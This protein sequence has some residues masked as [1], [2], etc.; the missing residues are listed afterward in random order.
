[1][2]KA[3]PRLLALI[4]CWPLLGW[5]DTDIN[6]QLPWD[7]EFRFAGY[8]A[9][10]DKGLYAKHDMRVNILSGFGPQ[11]TPI[12]PIEQ[13]LNGKAQFG[14]AGIE[15]LYHP[16]AND[17]LRILAPIFQQ[18]ATSLFSLAGTPLSKLQDLTGKRI[19]YIGGSSQYYE[20]QSLLRQLG[21]DTDSIV[22]TERNIDLNDL[23]EGRAD[24]IL[25]YGPQIQ[26]QAQ[27]RQ[28]AVNELA[29]NNFHRRYYGD[30][31]FTSAEFAERKPKHVADFMTASQ[32]GWHYALDHTDELV[33]TLLRKYPRTYLR[34][35]NLAAY[36]QFL[37][38][39]LGVY[40]QYPAVPVGYSDPV[41]WQVVVDALLQVGAIHT[42]LN[43]NNL[44]WKPEENT[45]DYKQ[46]L[47]YIAA[48]CLCI[49]LILYF[50]TRGRH[51]PLLVVLA[52][53]VILGTMLVERWL[54]NQKHELVKI[55]Q[56][57]NNM[58]MRAQIEG[59]LNNTLTGIHG[60]A[61]HISA[62]PNITQEDF[63]R[64]AAAMMRRDPSIRNIALAP[65]LKV[66]YVYPLEGNEAALELD[67]SKNDAQR[68]AAYRVR[69]RGEMVLAGPLELVQGGKA[70]IARAP[71]FV[72]T[73]NNEQIF[74]GL[75][76]APIDAP[77]L[78]LRAGLNPDHLLTPE[79]TSVTSNIAIRG[80]D[81]KGTLGEVFYGN[82][83]IFSHP[84]ALTVPINIGSDSWILAALPPQNTELAQSSLLAIRTL[85]LLVFIIFTLLISLL[86]K[87]EDKREQYEEN[88]RQN[89]R[90]LTEIGDMA[91]VAGLRIAGGNSITE[92]S[93]QAF[94]IMHIEPRPTPFSADDLTRNLSRVAGLKL[95]FVMRKC[96]DSKERQQTEIQVEIP[97]GQIQWI[98]VIF[99]PQPNGEL[100][101]A[102]QDITRQ[103]V[104]ENTIREQATMDRITQ[105][106]NRWFF[107]EQT[108]IEL[109][110]A[111]RENTKVAMLFIDVDNFKSI[112]DSLGH[113]TGDDF[114]RAIAARLRACTRESDVVARLGGDEFTVLLTNIDDYKNAFKVA[115][116][117]I[118]SMNQA[119]MLLGNQIF[120]SVS[121]G[122]SIFPDDA[123][124]TETL[125]SHADQAMYASKQSGKNNASFFTLAMQEHSERQHWIYNELVQAIEEDQLSVAYQP[126]FN[127]ADQTIADCEA[128]ARWHRPDGQTISPVEFIPVAESSG[129]ISRLDL[130]VLRKSLALLNKTKNM[131]VSV[132]I[133]PR[134]FHETE[135]G[136]A[137]WRAM[138]M[139][140][141][142]K[143]R[144]TVEIT[145]RLLVDDR[146]DAEQL[147]AELQREGLAISLDDFGTG[148]SSLSYLSRFNVNKLKIDRSFVMAIGRSKTQETL[149]ETILSMGE[150]LGIDVVAEGIETQEQ[151]EFLRERGCRYGQ[152]FLLAKPMPDAQ[153]MKLLREKNAIQSTS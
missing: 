143:T 26:Y 124:T 145:E 22:F 2:I 130:V 28:I 58:Q 46:L 86:R 61:T 56:L 78:M 34:Q 33:N 85:A 27:T 16:Q 148:Y 139:E 25:A 60:L 131:G 76:A 50:V 102:I 69:D 52:L 142:Q 111:K 117:I 59:V 119:F 19:A 72:S 81:G 114:L 30:I 51:R 49:A 47:P 1:M 65:D 94:N 133:S 73:E 54:I 99:S 96:Q 121:I 97:D 66:D 95:L 31:L 141:S 98:K 87:Q 39:S 18:T 20:L 151:L 5:A 9:A 79:T 134:L 128:L 13:V 149:I 125:L 140:H 74:W 91:Q 153:L 106:P 137:N 57:E 138:V 127:L 84:N 10:E 89:Q 12:D 3:I 53:T 70:F 44:L 108:A 83:A 7:H 38:N 75:V 71:V 67:Y 42:P 4:L 105:L 88:I 135:K 136:F 23:L 24:V 35:S 147:L 146:L 64:F 109:T 112:N 36:N 6:L 152:G 14:V 63:K 100:I 104:N 17:K 80:K 90:L 77:R 144:V 55:N 118:R 37:A 32:D 93:S 41:R 123:T 11:G 68:E 101:G 110:K 132:N 116:Q 107:T 150:K 40:I 62:Q 113:A 21:I 45:Q 126:I 103:K 115:E 129:L 48:L 43:V 82:A 92:I 120:S 15:L 29:L 122:I 8:Y